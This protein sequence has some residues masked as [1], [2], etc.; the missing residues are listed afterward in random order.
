M[1]SNNK[2]INFDLSKYIVDVYKRQEEDRKPYI[3]DFGGSKGL[4]DV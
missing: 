3:P 2:R 4:P 1:Q